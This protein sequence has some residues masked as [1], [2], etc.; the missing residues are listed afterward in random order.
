MLAQMS[1]GL[2]T[3]D[4][5]FSENEGQPLGLVKASLIDLPQGTYF[6]GGSDTLSLGSDN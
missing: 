2:V 1:Q 4:T 3:Y 6:H 5:I